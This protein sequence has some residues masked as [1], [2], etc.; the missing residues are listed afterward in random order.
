L[1]WQA[2]PLVAV[3]TVSAMVVVAVSVPDVPVIVTV[4]VPVAAEL[5]AA[6]VRTLLPVVGLVPNEAVTPLGK[7]DAASVTLPVNPPTSVTVMVS[8]PLLPCVIDSDEGD[9]ANVKPGVALT[10]TVSAIVVVADSVPDVPVIVTVE[11]PVVAVLLAVKVSTLLPVV[12]LVPNVAVTP[13]GKPDAA[14]VTLPVNPPVSVTEIVSVPLLPCV[15]DSD[16]GDDDS[17]KPGVVLA[18]TVSVMVVVA[19]TDPD[20]PVTVTV[21]APVVA[22]LLAVNVSTLLLVIGFVPNE[23]VTPLGKPDAARVTLP[24]KPPVSVT[25]MVSVALLP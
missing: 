23:A 8:V 9:D 19:V 16:E 24:V 22:V 1:M 2:N 14:S 21:N 13:L 20:V 7:P 17:V 6:S 15:I 3:L 4:E 12:G 5:L 11:D 25:V 18:L 10:L